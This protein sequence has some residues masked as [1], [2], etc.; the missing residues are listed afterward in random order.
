MWGGGGQKTLTAGSL[1][2]LILGRK[3][4]KVIALNMH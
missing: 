1:G 4:L 3:L 2:M